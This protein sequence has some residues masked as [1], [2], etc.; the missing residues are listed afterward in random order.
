M[1]AAVYGVF[2]GLLLGTPALLLWQLVVADLSWWA[3]LGPWIA[4]VVIVVG[5][6]AWARWI[7]Y[8][9]FM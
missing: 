5:F 1:R 4:L 6:M 3:V 7:S 2:L 9:P 8:N